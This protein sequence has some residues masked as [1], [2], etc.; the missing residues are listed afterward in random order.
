MKA[1][2]RP[3]Q[4]QVKAIRELRT[5]VQAEVYVGWSGRGRAALRVVANGTRVQ[6]AMRELR[7]A[8]VEEAGLLLKEAQDDTEAR[9][10]KAV[11]R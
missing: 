5:G 7:L 2:E 4:D 10:L 3:L 9:G 6:N 11:G 1:V 8:L